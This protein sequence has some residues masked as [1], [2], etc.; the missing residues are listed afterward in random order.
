VFFSG[1]WNEDSF[2]RQN[3]TRA[4]S[5]WSGGGWNGGGW[6]G[7]GGGWSNDNWRDG[8]GG[9]G[10]NWRDDNKGGGGRKGDRGNNGKG[11]GGKGGKVDSAPP[12]AARGPGEA[13]KPGESIRLNTNDC[14]SGLKLMG[15]TGSGTR[16]R[17][18][19]KA[20]SGTWAERIFEI[21]A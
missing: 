15:G 12:P 18:Q 6:K 14:E 16:E 20:D 19:R 21:C 5:G 3:R 13:L 4:M 2:Q 9:G 17:A 10:G 1:A 7:G 11:G 8:G